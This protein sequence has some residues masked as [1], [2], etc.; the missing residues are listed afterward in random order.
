MS[1]PEMLCSNQ[2]PCGAHAVSTSRRRSSRDPK[3]VITRQRSGPWPGRGAIWVRFS[4]S[5]NSESNRCVRQSADW[6]P[7]SGRST[8]I[9]PDFLFV[10][11]SDHLILGWISLYYNLRWND[12]P[13]G[14]D[15]LLS[16]KVLSMQPRIWLRRLQR[17]RRS[18]VC[19]TGALQLNSYFFPGLVIYNIFICIL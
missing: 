11:L 6:P 16:R 9:Q 17:T 4:I 13:I 1:L 5:H 19:K 2:W 10:S 12:H 14:A 15:F 3:N 18:W 7:P 8:G